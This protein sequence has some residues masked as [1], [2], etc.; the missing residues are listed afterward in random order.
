MTSQH[1]KI[2]CWHTNTITS[3][4]KHIFVDKPMQIYLNIQIQIFYDIQIQISIFKNKD[5]ARYSADGSN[6]AH[7]KVSCKC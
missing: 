7:N 4:H 5:M 2:I 6:L 3:Q 1:K